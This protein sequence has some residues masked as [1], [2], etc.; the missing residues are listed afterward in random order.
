VLRLVFKDLSPRA[1][2]ECARGVRPDFLRDPRREITVYRNDLVTADLGTAVCYGAIVDESQGRFWLFL[3][4]VPGRELYQ[5]GD[6]AAWEQAARW[7][8]TLH[9]LPVSGPACRDRKNRLIVYDGDYY[10]LWPRRARSIARP[11]TT[12]RALEW[13]LA[14]YEPVVERLVSLPSSFLHGEFYASN[15]LARAEGAGWRICP[16]DWEM[17]AFGPGL[18]DLAA[19]TTG[20][21][22]DAQREALALAYYAEWN[23]RGGTRQARAEFLSAL[24]CCRLHLALQWLG[25]S[26]GWSPPSEH[27]HDW[28]GEALRL[29]EQL[30]L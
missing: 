26:P 27:S 4:R 23:A 10:R 20:W 18:V 22:T 25:W 29:S 19:L 9:S 5:V 6:F 16:V 14:S 3:E 13:L 1:V 21:W 15:V 7:L 8:A 17:A 24:R 11:E 12:R 28:L 2:L 30:G